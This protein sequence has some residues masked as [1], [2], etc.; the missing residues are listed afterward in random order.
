MGNKNSS[1]PQKGNIKAPG[2][3]ASVLPFLEPGDGVRE[4][5]AYLRANSDSQLMAKLC[6]PVCR[7]EAREMSRH[8]VDPHSETPTTSSEHSVALGAVTRLATWL[9]MKP[10]TMTWFKRA[11]STS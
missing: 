11:V 1:S 8:M 6:K 9:W 7:P 3:L 2:Y 4:L 5:E 10:T